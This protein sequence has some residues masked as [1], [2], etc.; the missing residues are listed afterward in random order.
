VERAWLGIPPRA[1]FPGR[2]R[3]KS[4]AGPRRRSRRGEPRAACGRRRPN[5]VPRPA[6]DEVRSRATAAKPAG[7]TPRRVWPTAPQRGS[8]GRRR[9]EVRSRATAAKPAGRTPRRVW[10]TAPERGSQ[11]GGGRKSGAGPRRRSRRGEPRAACGRRRPNGVP[12]PAEDGVRSRA[13][14]AKPAGRTP[15]IRG[16]GNNCLAKR[17]WLGIPST[18]W[19]SVPGSVFRLRRSA[20]PPAS[21][22]T[23]SRRGPSRPRRTPPGSAGPRASPRRP[24]ALWP[25][26]APPA[27]PRPA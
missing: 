22:S 5:G 14:A 9:T 3:T 6:E 21:S 27:S 4:G 15:R 13:T 18:A 20:H 25:S 10:P 19:W 8:R 1:G 2:R 12:R 11:A 17:A 16:S 26:R 23:A 24:R 7:R